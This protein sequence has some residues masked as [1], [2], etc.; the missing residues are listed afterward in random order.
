MRLRVLCFYSRLCFSRF[1]LR[2]Y[3]VTT[4]SNLLFG[5]SCN[6]NWTACVMSFLPV[7]GWVL[8]FRVIKFFG[9]TL[10]IIKTDFILQLTSLYVNSE[11][12][13]VEFVTLI[14]CCLRAAIR[15]SNKLNNPNQN[16]TSKHLIKISFLVYF[17][18]YLQ[19]YKDCRSTKLLRLFFWQSAMFQ[20]IELYTCLPDFWPIFL[21][22]LF[23]GLDYS[24]L[25]VQCQ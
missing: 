7:L 1:L 2:P 3:D 14:A 23:F 18:Y 9:H 6:F 4:N 21:S 16:I 12:R 17:F 11:S 24:S 19:I 22:F 20:V 13:A 5:R 8:F 25:F 15:N 10:L